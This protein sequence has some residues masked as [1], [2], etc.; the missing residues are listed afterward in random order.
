VEEG[1]FPELHDRDDLWQVLRTLS[2][3]K[4]VNLVKDE[5]RQKRGGGKV[6]HLSTLEDEAEDGPFFASLIS[7]EPDPAFAAEGAE[8]PWGPT[9]AARR[10][11]TSYLSPRSPPG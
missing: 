8:Q 3:R 4:A 5:A 11:S 1:R 9:G 2:A 7:E 6:R 10:V